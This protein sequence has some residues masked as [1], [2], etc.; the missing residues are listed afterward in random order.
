[1]SRSVETKTK[2]TCDLCRKEWEVP[3]QISADDRFVIDMRILPEMVEGG[4]IYGY[5]TREF[6]AIDMCIGCQA[7]VRETIK[8]LCTPPPKE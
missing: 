3:S 7:A 6:K 4:P 2:V 1:M 5:F 8:L